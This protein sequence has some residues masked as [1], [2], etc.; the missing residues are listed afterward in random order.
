MTREARIVGENGRSVILSGPAP[1]GDG[2]WRYT[3]TLEFETGRASVEVWDYGEPALPGLLRRVADNWRGFDTPIAFASIEGQFELTLTHDGKGTI[4]CVATLRQPW[5]PTWT[6][7][8]DLSYGAGANA[9]QVARD[10]E[11]I[12]QAQ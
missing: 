5:P 11:A 10:F 12:F 8:I 3:V 9:E 2:G 6:T 1:D 7:T 4:D